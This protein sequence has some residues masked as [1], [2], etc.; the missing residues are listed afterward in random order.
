MQGLLKQFPID[1]DR[2][3]WRLFPTSITLGFLKPICLLNSMKSF[4][5]N[6]QCHHPLIVINSVHA[7][8]ALWLYRTWSITI[9]HQFSHYLHVRFWLD[10]LLHRELKTHFNQT[11]F[12]KLTLIQ[13]NDWRGEKWEMHSFYAMTTFHQANNRIMQVVI[14]SPNWLKF[15][16]GVS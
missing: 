2:E 15:L 11:Y 5:F 3:V 12:A 4:I 1:H 6:D 8:G 7:F 14:P 13:W 10:S 16:I 9:K